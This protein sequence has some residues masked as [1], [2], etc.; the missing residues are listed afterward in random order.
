MEKNKPR[1]KNIGNPKHKTNTKPDEHLR[2]PEPNASQNS[3]AISSTGKMEA[4]FPGDA[5]GDLGKPI[6]NQ[7]EQEKITNQGSGQPVHGS[8]E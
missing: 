5:N 2:K 6:T 3:D 4:F 7:D 8:D 1:P